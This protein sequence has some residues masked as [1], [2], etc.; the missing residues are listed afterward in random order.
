[1]TSRNAH[2]T[3]SL[4]APVSVMQSWPTPNYDDP[5]T[6]SQAA[7]IVSIILGTVMLVVVAAR[8]WARVFIQ[9]S[10]GADDWIIV[11]ALVSHIP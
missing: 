8:L 4:V 11:A 10:F 1:M 2:G 6:R 5:V 9:R 7:L 3:S